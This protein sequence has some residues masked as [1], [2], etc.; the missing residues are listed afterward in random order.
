VQAHKTAMKNDNDCHSSY[1]NAVNNSMHNQTK[2][3]AAPACTT[4]H[5][6][7]DSGHTGLV[8]NESNTCRNCHVDGVN[9]FY[10]R[11]TGSSDC[12]S[13]HFANTTQRFTGFNE[14]L[15]THDH[16]LTVEH[17]FYEYNQS[18]MPVRT[19]AALVWECSRT[20]HAR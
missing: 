3:A 7:Y 11:H 15:F 14:S 20:I 13:C 2:N 8:V 18:G 12:T 5:T 9:G 10:E 4:C 17:N 19:M 6:N 16:N 1:V